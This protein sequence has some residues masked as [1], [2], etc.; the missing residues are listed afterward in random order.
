MS[1]D[2]GGVDERPGGVEVHVRLEGGGVVLELGLDL[3]RLGPGGGGEGGVEGQLE[4]LHHLGTG[5]TKVFL[6][7]ERGWVF[8]FAG[9]KVNEFHSEF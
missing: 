3:A 5:K 9:Q 8:P 2:G 6:M 1:D 7:T 4:A